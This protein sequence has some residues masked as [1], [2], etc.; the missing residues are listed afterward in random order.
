MTMM[1]SP[2]LTESMST[3][4][5]HNRFA[6][7]IEGGEVRASRRLVLVSGPHNARDSDTDIQRESEVELAIDTPREEV[8][9]QAMPADPRRRR[10]V[11]VGGPNEDAEVVDVLRRER[12]EADTE[13]LPSLDEGSVLSRDE[14][15][16][17]PTPELEVHEPVRMAIRHAFQSMDVVDL[18]SEFN[19]R[20]CMMKTVPVFLKGPFRCALQTALAEIFCCIDVSDPIRRKK[21]WKLLMLLPRM[22]LHKPPRGGFISKAKLAARFEV[23]SHG[24]WQKLIDAGRHCA[25]K[26]AT[27]VSRKRRRT[28]QQSDVER[29]AIRAQN[30]V[31]LGEFSQALEGPI[32]SKLGRNSP[33]RSAAHPIKE[34]HCLPIC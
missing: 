31:Q 22:L 26:A 6:L 16:E 15:T 33:I 5:V 2:H 19:R 7:L 25:E 29:R 28:N 3:V 10:L 21:G 34:N 24:R 9:E 4:V 32:R 1:A 18:G 13:T 20:A 27:A 8:G 17:M 23:F 14:E 12:G 30:L 11:L